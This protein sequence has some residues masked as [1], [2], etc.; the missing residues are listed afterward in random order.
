MTGPHHRP[1]P[2]RRG[3]SGP[4]LAF[5]SLLGSLLAA[6]LFLQLVHPLPDPL[7]PTRPTISPGLTSRTAS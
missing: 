7:L 2:P 6:E 3:P 4:V 1:P 5:L